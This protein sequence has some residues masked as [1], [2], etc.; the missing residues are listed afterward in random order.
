MKEEVKRLEQEVKVLKERL[1][2]CE[3]KYKEKED[4][5]TKYKDMDAEYDMCAAELKETIHISHQVY[6]EKLL[7]E[8]H[9]PYPFYCFHKQ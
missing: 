1:E 6:T 2:A 3:S 8:V 5:E 9:S 7:I 4:W